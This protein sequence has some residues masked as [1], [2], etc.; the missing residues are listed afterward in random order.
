M[1]VEPPPRQRPREEPDKD[2]EKTKKKRREEAEAPEDE[3]ENTRKHT[4]DEFFDP[5]LGPAQ[6]E[7]EEAPRSTTTTR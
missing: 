1:N 2:E 4:D 5:T 3:G 6:P 7:T